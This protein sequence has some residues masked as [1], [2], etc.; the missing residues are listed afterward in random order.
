MKNSQSG[1]T[2]SKSSPSKEKTENSNQES[3]GS[4]PF[5]KLF[6]DSLKDMYW[7]EKALVKS[8]PKM[9]KKAT[10]E[11]LIA[12]LEDHLEVTKAQVTKVEQ[13]FEVIGKKPQAKA[14]AAMEGILEEATE[15][16]E[17]FEGIT[18][19]AAIIYAAQKVEHYEI[20]SYGTLCA[21]ANTLGLSEAANMLKEIL[22]EEKD[23]D[24]KLTEIAVTS[25]NM[26]ATSEVEEEEEEE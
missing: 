17:E 12:A 16:M 8:I 11:E 13:V 26:E 25:I 18:G 23:A 22:D 3:L 1:T 10:S 9:I 14:C 20:A 7:V 6:E 19:D 5:E 4:T 24:G 15:L 2:K 21:F